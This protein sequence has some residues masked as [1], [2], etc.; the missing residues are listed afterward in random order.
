VVLGWTLTAKTANQFRD[1]WE[2]GVGD[3][4]F[5]ADKEHH[6]RF[7]NRALGK[8]KFMQEVLYFADV[9]YR[10]PSLD[11]MATG[12]IDQPHGDLRTRVP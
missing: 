7:L 4:Q 8:T 6:Q 3:L 10:V 11:S 1:R 5:G 12:S 9:P 2:L